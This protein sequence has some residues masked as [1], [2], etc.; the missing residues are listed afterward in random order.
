MAHGGRTHIPDCDSKILSCWGGS[1][2]RTEKKKV[3]GTT[4]CL[5]I[6]AWKVCRSV[7]APAASY[8]THRATFA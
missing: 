1:T 3:L 5:G 8:H 4:D 6:S 7:A 2:N